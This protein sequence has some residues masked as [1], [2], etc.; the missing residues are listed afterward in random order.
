M[1]EPQQPDKHQHAASHGAS[2]AAGIASMRKPAEPIDV[3]ALFDDAN[4]VGGARDA[5]YDAGP[6]PDVM[7]FLVSRE[8]AARDYA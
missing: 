5:Q 8:A 6:P 1:T 2:V 7:Q 3:T 4:A